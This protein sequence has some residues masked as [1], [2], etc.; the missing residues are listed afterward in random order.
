[1]LKAFGVISLP[2]AS[3]AFGFCGDG[4]VGEDRGADV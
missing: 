4:V 1:M 2:S 3:V